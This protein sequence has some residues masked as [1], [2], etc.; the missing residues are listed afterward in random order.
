M[1]NESRFLEE[2]GAVRDLL[3]DFGAGFFGNYCEL[4]RRWV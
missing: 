1:V 2:V 4:R 3:F